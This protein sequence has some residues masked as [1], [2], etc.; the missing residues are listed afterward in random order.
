MTASLTPALALDFITALS[1]DIRA[2]VV[3]DAAGTPLAGPQALAAAAQA[4]PQGDPRPDHPH[5]RSVQ[6]EGATGTGG[7]FAARDERHTI[8]VVTGPFALARVT[9]HDLRT[10]LS[11]LGGQMAPIDPPERLDEALVVA[12]LGAV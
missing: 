12:L 11:A 5:Q 9:R 7:V 4:L 2:A 1:A 8:V 3:L 6:F 10:A